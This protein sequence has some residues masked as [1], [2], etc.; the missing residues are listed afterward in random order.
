MKRFILFGLIMAFGA[1]ACS[2]ISPQSEVPVDQEG[3]VTVFALD[4]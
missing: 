1:T 3:V 4:G 2:P